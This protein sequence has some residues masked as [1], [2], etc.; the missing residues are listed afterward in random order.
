M[1]TQENRMNP[2][3]NLSGSVSPARALNDHYTAPSHISGRLLTIEEK[4]SYAVNPLALIGRHFILDADSTYPL[5]FKVVGV[6]ISEGPTIIEVFF[7]G[8]SCA[9]AL[10]YKEV[11]DMIDGSTFLSI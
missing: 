5:P 6:K 1:S 2:Q 7:A 4:A 9:E 11:M 10:E 3:Y 8:C